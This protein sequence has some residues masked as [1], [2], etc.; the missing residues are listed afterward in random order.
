MTGFFYKKAELLPLVEKL[1]HEF[2]EVINTLCN[3]S[4]SQVEELG[5]LEG[6]QTSSSYLTMCN[7]LVIEIQQKIAQRKERL[8][9]YVKTK[10]EFKNSNVKHSLQIDSDNR[11]IKDLQAIEIKDSI[12]LLKNILY[13]LQMATLP[14]YPETRHI[15]I[16]KILSSNMSLLE[17]NLTKLF[18]LEET[19]LVPKLNEVEE[20][21]LE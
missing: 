20:C 5:L 18:Y 10:N 6:K 1:D 4:K 17:H 3:K 21:V 2:Y 13:R 19:Y 8:V 11:P 16:Y 7:A 9:N 14:L 15:E 12:W